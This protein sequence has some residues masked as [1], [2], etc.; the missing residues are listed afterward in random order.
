MTHV[1]D[2]PRATTNPLK[3]IVV[4]PGLTMGSPSRAN[5]LVIGGWSIMMSVKTDNRSTTDKNY[6]KIG[7]AGD[8]QPQ[9]IFFAQ[10]GANKMQLL[11]SFDRAVGRLPHLFLGSR[12][13]TP[14]KKKKGIGSMPIPFLWRGV[15]M[16]QISL[17]ARVRPR[18]HILICDRG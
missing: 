8:P 10:L 14:P 18:E 12:E 4:T 11:R 5:P 13:T 6:V 17:L 9:K 16:C 7:G 3:R 2:I 1:I 15:R